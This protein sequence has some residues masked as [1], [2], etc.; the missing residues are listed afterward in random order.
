M[1]ANLTVDPGATEN[2]AKV[3][4]PDPAEADPAMVDRWQVAPLQPLR[5]GQDPAYAEIPAAGARWDTL[6]A[7]P[8]GFLNLNRRYRA[9]DAPPSLVW[10][11]TELDADADGPRRVGGL[12]AGGR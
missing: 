12:R 8:S 5:Y 11:R 1:F 2:L 4:V 7:D 9:S 10:L 6:A 3:S